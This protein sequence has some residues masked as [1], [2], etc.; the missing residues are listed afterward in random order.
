MY[1]FSN[2]TVLQL[3]TEHHRISLLGMNVEKGTKLFN[4]Q[5]YIRTPHD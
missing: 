2:K 3:A 1:N 5:P 4:F